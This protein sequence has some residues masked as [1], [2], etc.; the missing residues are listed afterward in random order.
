MNE[1]T[2]GELAVFCENVRLLRQKYGY[3]QERMAKICGV[4]KNTLSKI[5]QMIFP[6]RLGIRVVF[7]ICWHFR[8]KPYQLFLPLEFP[9]KK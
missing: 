2:T 4:N 9:E 7:N 6:P 3:S 1:T 8:L 5:E